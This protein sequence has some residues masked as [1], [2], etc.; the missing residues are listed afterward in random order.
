[1]S[2]NT[3][4]FRA[5]GAAAVATTL[6]LGLGACSSDSSDAAKGTEENPVVIGVVNAEADDQ[7]PIFEKAAED[8]GIFVEIKDLGDY[9]TPNAALTSGELDLNQFQHLQF[10]A[11]Y[12]VNTG[13][14][15]TPI[16]GTA[17]YPLSIYST[18][19]DSVEDIPED[20]EI[21][22]PNDPTN[23]A[24]ALLLLQE[25]GLITLKDGGSSS[26]TE[27]DI[28]ADESKVNVTAVDATQTAVNL[29]TLDGAVVNNDFVKDSGL[30]P[31]EALF[32]DSADSVGARPY[33]NVWVARA[34]DKDN[35]T[36][37]KLV[38]ISHSPEVEAALQAISK[39]TAVISNHSAEELQ[40]FLATIQEGLK[41]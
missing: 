11:E 34:Q 41:G 8:A 21:A 32:A 33:I 31:T 30:E 10:L 29:D 3:R 6:A 25:A 5:L 36:Y 19:H 20:A 17:I 23:G 18:K 7:W 16:G 37:L 22:I 12:N 28:I 35:E 26:S 9:N 13:E 15:L 38:E 2:R 4:S 14:D 1:M 39:G 27:D 40:G 24:R